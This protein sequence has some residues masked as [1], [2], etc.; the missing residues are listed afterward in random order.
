M[1][2]YFVCSSRDYIVAG[3]KDSGY[4]TANA[5]KR[6]RSRVDAKDSTFVAMK[7]VLAA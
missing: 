4:A 6:A 3:T 1:E 5:A 2:R 7:I